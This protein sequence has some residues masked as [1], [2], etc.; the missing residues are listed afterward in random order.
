MKKLLAILLLLAVPVFAQVVYPPEGASGGNG[1]RVL[2]WDFTGTSGTHFGSGVINSG[3]QTQIDGTVP[4]PGVVQV[5]NNSNANGGVYWQVGGFSFLIGGGEA[6]VIVFQVDAATDVVAHLGFQD[7]FTAAEPTDGVYLNIDGTTLDG[8]TADNGTRSTTTSSYTISTGTWYTGRVTVNSDASSVSYSLNDDTGT[9]LWSDTLATNIPTT[10]GRT[11]GAGATAYKTTAADADF[12]SYD[13]VEAAS[14]V[15]AARGAGGGAGVNFSGGL[16][17]PLLGPDGS[18]TAP[19]YSIASAPSSGMWG[20]SGAIIVSG[21]DGSGTDAAGGTVA[22]QGGA[23]T[24]TGGGGEFNVQV[25]PKGATSGSTPNSYSPVIV[26]NAGGTV[27]IGGLDTIENSLVGDTIIAASDRAASVT[28][29]EAGKL[30][31]R[32][33]LS[34]GAAAPG[35][36][37]LQTGTTLG[38]GTTQQTATTRMTIDEAD[39]T[40]TVPFLQAD[41]ADTGPSYSFT[42]NTTAGLWDSSDHIILQGKRASGTDTASTGTYLRSGVGTGTAAGGNI[43]LTI[44]PG[45]AASGSSLNTLQGAFFAHGAQGYVNIG[46]VDVNGYSTPSLSS[47]MGVDSAAGNTDYDGGAVVIRGGFGTG[48][49]VP[50]WIYL[51]TGSALGSGSTQQTESNRL[52][53]KPQGPVVSD[54]G[55]KPTCDSTIRGVLWRDQGGAGVADT[56]EVCAKNSSDTYAWYALA[57]IP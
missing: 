13:Y 2:W 5:G 31:L 3:N 40:A 37:R 12:I 25:T 21:A 42:D 50:G 15:L 35:V 7:S 47:W 14:P 8:M 53:I 38:S 30:Y 34:T 36:I 52:I 43:S 26:A 28:D 57:T 10:A 29:I 17:W 44:A 11:T 22:L 16:T 46:G 24:G 20:A 4:H 56:F 49:G 39:V 45:G 51:R 32:G 27:T 48:A 33:G 9:L 23:S 41:G 6:F 55:T 18:A 19:S 1:T 54:S